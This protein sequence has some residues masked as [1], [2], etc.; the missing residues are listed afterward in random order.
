M[1]G[2]NV[3]FVLIHGAWHNSMSWVAVRPIL[4]ARGHRVYA[5]DLPG[6]GVYAKFPLSYE[7]RP[8]DLDAFASEPTPTTVTQDERT[9]A[10]SSALREIAAKTGQSAIVVAHSL[11]GATGTAVAEAVPE[12]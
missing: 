4:E 10:I 6:A 5:L 8:L 2:T 1:S 9:N 12:F 7:A 11:G 3:P